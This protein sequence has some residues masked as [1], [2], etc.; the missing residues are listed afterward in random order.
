MPLGLWPSVF[1]LRSEKQLAHTQTFGSHSQ[2]RLCS[3]SR[4]SI[5]LDQILPSRSQCRNISRRQNWRMPAG[6]GRLAISL[7]CLALHNL[8]TYLPRYL[9]TIPLHTGDTTLPSS[10]LQPNPRTSHL[11]SRTTS[12][13]QQS[14]PEGFILS[15]N[16]FVILSPFSLL[17]VESR[18]HLVP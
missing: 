15:T 18:R 16:S 12:E 10:N 8:P 3:E 9:A 2:W 6:Q 1:T 14:R 5:P 11:L 4:V 7:L 13:A 17:R